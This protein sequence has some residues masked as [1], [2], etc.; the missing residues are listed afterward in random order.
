MI[1]LKRLL[2][3]EDKYY[4]VSKESG[5]T[6]DFKSEETRDAA[7]KAG[8]HSKPEKADDETPADKEPKKADDFWDYTDD[9]GDEDE[10]RYSDDD[11]EDDAAKNKIIADVEALVGKVDSGYWTDTGNEWEGSEFTTRIARDNDSEYGAY[12]LFAIANDDDDDLVFSINNEDGEPVLDLNDTGYISPKNMNKR[13]AMEFLGNLLKE[14]TIKSLMEDKGSIE[15]VKA[16]DWYK[17]LESGAEP[18]DIFG[19]GTT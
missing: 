14:P 19:G 1:S 18:G 5:K 15:D 13:E 16:T 4:A 7:I 11:D 17:R 2:E 8:T 10:A 12:D 6:V 9:E 3:G